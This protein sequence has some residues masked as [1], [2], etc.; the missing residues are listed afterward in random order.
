VPALSVVKPP[1]SLIIPA[2]VLGIIFF[3]F[4]AAVILSAFAC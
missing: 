1:L 4:K 3:K 2:S